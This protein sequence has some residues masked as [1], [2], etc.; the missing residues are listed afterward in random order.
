MWTD[1]RTGDAGGP[2][3]GDSGKDSPGDDQL[4]HNYSNATRRRIFYR[5][6]NDYVCRDRG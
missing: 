6:F 2:A 4:F 3:V 1:G 5:E